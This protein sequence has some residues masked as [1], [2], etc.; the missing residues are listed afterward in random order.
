MS[1]TPEQPEQWAP[2]DFVPT[3]ELVRRQGV[4]P[5]RSIDDLAGADPFESDDEYEAFLAD[6]HESRRSSA[7]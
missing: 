2:D 5:V 6:L 1:T 7:S 3:Q 4:R